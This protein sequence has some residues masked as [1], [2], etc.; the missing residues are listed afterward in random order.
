[1]CLQTQI[2]LLSCAGIERGNEELLPHPGRV[3]EVP[4][5]HWG[6]QDALL[7]PVGRGGGGCHGQGGL[8]PGHVPQERGQVQMVQAGTSPRLV[9]E[10]ESWLKL[11]IVLLPPTSSPLQPFQ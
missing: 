2:C 5:Q 1:M 6:Q 3:H 8:R 4:G 11:I 10:D 9:I 7:L